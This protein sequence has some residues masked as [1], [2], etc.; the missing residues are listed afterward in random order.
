MKSSED[1][2]YVMRTFYAQELKVGHHLDRYNL[3][4][5][6]PMRMVERT[7]TPG[8]AR[9]AQKRST[10]YV[11]NLIFIKKPEDPQILQRAID[12]S[13]YAAQMYCCADSSE[14][15][16][17]PD[18]DILELRIICDQSFT[19]PIFISEEESEL[20]VG[21]LVEVKHGPLKGMQGRLVRKNKKYYM[22][23]SYVGL[24]VKICVSRWCCRE[25]KENQAPS[26]K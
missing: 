5:F 2:W 20:M 23:K 18:K 21:S 11:H 16:Q 13:P 26:T 19:V 15:Q 1:Y 24:G 3:S 7:S 8:Q 4:W 9:K 12:E 14:W 10:P 25:I 17:I 22:V 6:I